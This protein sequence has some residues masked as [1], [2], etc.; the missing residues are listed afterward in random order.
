MKKFI[1]VIAIGSFFLILLLGCKAHVDMDLKVDYSLN[2]LIFIAAI[3]EDEFQK[4][5]TYPE[6]LKTLENKYSKYLIE[7]PEILEK[8]LREVWW[9]KPKNLPFDKTGF[10]VEIRYLVNKDR[11]NYYLFAAWSEYDDKQIKKLTYESLSNKVILKNYRSLIGIISKGKVI[12]LALTDKI[13]CGQINLE[14]V[15][16]NMRKI[17]KRCIP[18]IFD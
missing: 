16:C 12:D 8:Y 14:T 13:K 18:I 10:D 17:D 6:N 9:G 5:N 15:E 4:N 3:L 7:H 11:T 1:S 2:K